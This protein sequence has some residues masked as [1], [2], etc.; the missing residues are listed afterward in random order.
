MIL[1]FIAY[2]FDDAASIIACHGLIGSNIGLM[3]EPSKASHPTVPAFSIAGV[4]LR[5]VFKTAETIDWQ[6]AQSFD[7]S[8]FSPDFRQQQSIGIALLQIARAS[9]CLIVIAVSPLCLMFL[10]PYALLCLPTMQ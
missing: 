3:G 10:T 1:S 8:A 5:S 6:V 7:A 9:W 2:S 4:G